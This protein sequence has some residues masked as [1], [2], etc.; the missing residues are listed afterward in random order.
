MRDT[1]A[2]PDVLLE[3]EKAKHSEAVKLLTDCGRS[4]GKHCAFHLVWEDAHRH[5]IP[6]CRRVVAP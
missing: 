4:A 3:G 1:V 2:F 5:R 6:L